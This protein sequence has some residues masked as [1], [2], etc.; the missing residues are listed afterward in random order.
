MPTKMCIRDRGGVLGIALG[1][2]VSMAANRVLP[3]FMTDTTVTVSPSFNS[4]C[5]LYTSRCV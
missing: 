3:M 2:A 4:I 5:L 1:Y